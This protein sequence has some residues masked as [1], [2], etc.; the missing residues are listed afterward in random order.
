MTDHTTTTSTVAHDAQTFY[1]DE[2]QRIAER[3]TAHTPGQEPPGMTATGSRLLAGS[4]LLD[5]ADEPDLTADLLLDENGQG[6]FYRGMWN[7]LAGPRGVGKSWACLE[8]TR[9]EITAG[10]DVLLLDFEQLPRRNVKRLLR[11]GVPRDLIE[12]HLTVLHYRG[13]ISDITWTEIIG[14]P[15]SLVIVDS[16]RAAMS[17][18]DGG[19]DESAS[20]VERFISR[21]LLPLTHLGAGVIVT[22][23]KRKA[24][25]TYTDQGPVGSGR[26]IDACQGAAY[27][28]VPLL[29]PADGALGSFRLVNDKDNE[30]AIKARIPDS[31]ERGNLVQEAAYVEVDSRPGNPV[32]TVIRISGPRDA[33]QIARD[34]LDDTVDMLAAAL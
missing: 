4:G 28:I 11:M 20:D 19:V 5:C 27:T 16:F 32:P 17:A 8:A 21:R 15:W 26:K 24:D 29:T 12:R 13:G 22:D 6:L 31:R 18:L 30:G 10:R 2:V 23:H 3:I 9:Q 34:K 7:L 1:P 25:T 14:T 33:S